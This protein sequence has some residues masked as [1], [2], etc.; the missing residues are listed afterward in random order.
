MSAPPASHGA[1]RVAYVSSSLETTDGWGR[2]TVELVRAARACG[3]QPVLVTTRDAPS[4]LEIPGEVH[5]VLPPLPLRRRESFAQLAHAARLG[6]VLASCDVVHLVVEPYLPLVARAV[7]RRT[8]V[9]MTAHGTWA[10]LPL[11]DRLTGWLHRRA[12]ERVDLLVCQSAATRDAMARLARLPSHRVLPG[13]VRPRSFCD[14]TSANDGP[15]HPVVLTVGA[16][17][18]RKGHDRALETLVRAAGRMG[19]PVHWVVVG[20]TDADRPW[21]DEVARRATEASPSVAA[22]WLGRADED[23]LRA[24]Y[25]RASLFLLLPVDDRGAF[26]GLGLVLLE[27]AAAGL[28]SVTWAG[29]GAAEAVLDDRTGLV[30]ANGDIEAAA[31][32]VARVLADDELRGRLSAGARAF[33]AER[34]WE[35]LA[36]ELSAHYR[37]LLARGRS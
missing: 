16:V 9:V 18:R 22:E 37:Q 28:P 13:G 4:S 30:V 31:T 21:F 32:A 35:R 1:P 36:T 12:L 24:W 11:A 8:P 7:P 20:Q 10:V 2:Y 34:S 3:I 33:A 29:G 17:K 25:R 5:R 26:E 15:A 23:T 19:R 14:A 27:A 6:R